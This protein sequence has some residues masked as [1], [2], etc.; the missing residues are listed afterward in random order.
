MKDLTKLVPSIIHKI[1]EFFSADE[2]SKQACLNL[3]KYL[4]SSPDAI[5]EMSLV[6]VAEAM[7]A[8]DPKTVLVCLD[9]CAG[10]LGLIDTYAVVHLEG[11][12]YELTVEELNQA[13]RSG[14]VS[15]PK[16]GALQ[17]FNHLRH[18]LYK[19]SPSLA[20]QA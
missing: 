19:L 20:V 8:E 7:D 16:T 12:D 10:P 6:D 17:M 11:Q 2:K 13:V 9:F 4:F 18:P 3:A 1:E 15:N 14:R 5:R